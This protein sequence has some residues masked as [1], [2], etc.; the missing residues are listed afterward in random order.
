ME[1]IIK[2]LQNGNDSGLRENYSQAIKNVLTA[3][4]R[5]EIG[6]GG[7]IQEIKALINGMENTANKYWKE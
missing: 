7:F 1:E 3:S 6:W 2:E 4:A 5:G